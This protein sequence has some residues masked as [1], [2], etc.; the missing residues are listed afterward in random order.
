MSLIDKE[1]FK[2]KK[3]SNFWL[4]KEKFKLTKPEPICTTNTEGSVA[5]VGM[6]LFKK[7]YYCVKYQ[8][9]KESSKT[10]KWFILNDICSKCKS[11]SPKN[12]KI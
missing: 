12:T 10:G 3:F 9:V 11:F 8:K 4:W 6:G 5:F 2:I 7:K 1:S